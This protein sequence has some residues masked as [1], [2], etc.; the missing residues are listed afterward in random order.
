MYHRNINQ[1]KI[2]LNFNEFGFDSQLVEGIEAIGYKTATP[3]QE[4]VI[5]PIIA[6]KDLI[7]SAQTGTGKTAAYLLPIIHNILTTPHTD[8]IKA[9]VIV[10]TRE[11]AIQI[12]QQ[13][14]GFSYFTPVSSIAV[15]GGGDGAS[16]SREKDAMASGADMVICT[17]GRMISH[18]NLQYLDL[19]SLQYLI[20]DEADR[21]LDIGF[22]DDIMKII[23][24]LPEKRQ[25]LLFSATMP[26]KIRDLA[27]KILKNPQ[28][29][30]IAISTPPDK[31]QQEAYVVYEAQKTPLV[32]HILTAKKRRSVLVFCSTK[33][34]VKQ[35]SRELKK[36][37]LAIEEIHSDLD[38][39]ARE[40]VMMNFRSRTLNILVATDIIS[41]GI[42]IEDIDLVINYDV[43]ND[44]E[45]YIHRI[46]R[47]ARAESNGEAI[48]F[49]SEREQ[50]RFLTIENLLGKEVTKV[51]LP[52]KF[53][54]APE[55]N[56]KAHKK[57][58]HHTNNKTFAHKGKKKSGPPRL[59]KRKAIKP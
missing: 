33:S 20:L 53:G 19:K 17:P 56:P 6:G 26:N 12:E 23:S 32:K 57:N 10:P 54:E 18:L 8:K 34:N 25:S 52:E 15:Y 27:R 45:D 1:R 43:P 22:Y 41:R 46:G 21:M 58:N 47:T 48:T 2:T 40:N 38:Q 9:M 37:G 11:L 42:D 55:Y 44:G 13:M 7:A 4:L 49:I 30:N 16:Y 35:L 14:E 5:P 24:F 29:V 36:I 3:I 31:I 51:A 39:D 50:G 28:E 59:E